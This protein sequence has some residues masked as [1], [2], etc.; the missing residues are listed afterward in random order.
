MTK[1][2]VNGAQ[3]KMGQLICKILVQNKYE[4]LTREIGAENC[5]KADL[6]IDFSSPQGAQES[7]KIAKEMKAAFL[8]GTTNLPQDLLNSFEAEK[9]IP[10]F[11]APNVSIGV[12]LFQKLL[13]EAKKMYK[14]YTLALHEIHHTQ[15]KDAPSGT[16]KKLAAALGVEQE[17]ITYERIGSVPGTHSLTLTS[18]INDEEIILTHK[19][20]DRQMLAQSAVSVGKWLLKQ[21][22]GF[23]NMKDF[24]EDL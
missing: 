8:C 22:A 18:P 24:L 1:V 9:Q 11:Y 7:Y 21:K 19:V 23:Y 15:K 5:P 10:L 14:G 17:K 4:V 2:L 12:A 6:I 13:L 20:L 3:G 16:A